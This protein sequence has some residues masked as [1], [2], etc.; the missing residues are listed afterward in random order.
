MTLRLYDTRAQLL[1]DFV[2]LD[3]ENITMYVCGPTVQ[4]GPHIGHV[5]AAL[6]FDLLRRWLTYRHGRVTFVRNVTDIDDKV[7]ANA[8]ESEPWWALAYRMEREFAAAYAGIGILPP[9]YEPRATA[10]VP[11]M[12]ELIALLIDRGHA[13]PAPDGSGDVYFDVRSWPSYGDLTHQSVDAME[14]AQDADPRGKRNPQDFAL[15]KGAKADEPADATWASPWGAGRPGWHIECSAMAKRY[16][17]AE[18]DIHG[19]GLDLRFPHHENELAQSSAAG[20]GFARYWVHNGLVTVDGQKMSK[21]LG[22]FTLAR[23]VL[24]ERDPLVV[25]YALAA[26]HYRSSLDLSE[27]SWAE[28]EAALGRI[29]SFLERALR[30]A[31]YGIGADDAQSLPSAFID[32]MDDDLGVPQALAVVHES[33][34]AGNSALDAGD[35]AAALDAA[36]AVLGMTG[37]LGLVEDAGSRK[38]G[39]AQAA[40]LDA[41]VQEMIAQRATARAEKDWA[42]ADR[43]RDAI[44]A[45]GITLEDTPAGTHWSIDG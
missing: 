15:W 10:S 39:D 41:L 23:D 4:S 42:A 21:S 19:G 1:R 38:A 34:R 30:A 20:D 3:P 24:A 9:T 33:V 2:P 11:Q 6:S 14:A 18:F 35:T 28:A 43:I 32:A 13:Y 36:R 5:R 27:S 16:L 8:S 37:V 7:L 40:A 31:G 26:A 25:R 22:N 17:G 29:R 45:A 44:A 12:Q